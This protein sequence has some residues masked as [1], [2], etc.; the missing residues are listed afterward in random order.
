MQRRTMICDPCQRGDHDSCEEGECQCADRLDRQIERDVI[1]YQ[2]D[3][4]IVETIFS[5]VL[6]SGSAVARMIVK[7][8]GKG[9]VRIFITQVLR[10]YRAMK[11]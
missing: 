3:E 4:G 8:A 11:N 2:G 6:Y 9:N 7:G 1:G 10:A 5:N